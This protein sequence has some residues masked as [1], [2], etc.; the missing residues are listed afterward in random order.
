MRR[1]R[2]R[3]SGQKPSRLVP[4]SGNSTRP[5]GTRPEHGLGHAPGKVERGKHDEA[6]RG[7]S[8]P[9]VDLVGR[10]LEYGLKPGILF[11]FE[12]LTAN[13]LDYPANGYS[14]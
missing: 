9:K 1:Y 2:F 10:K 6:G 4:K 3:G 8:G 13:R 7:K 11:V 12:L 5:A 14:G